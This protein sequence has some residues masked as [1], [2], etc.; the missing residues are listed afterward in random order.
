IDPRRDEIIRHPDLVEK[1]AEIG[2]K[3]VFIGLES[4][5]DEELRSLNKKCTVE[6]NNRA[7]EILHANNV[8]PLGAF[9]IQ[10]HYTRKH[11]DD[12]L[13]YL[14]R[15]RIYYH[16]FTVLTPFPGTEFYNQV[17]DEVLESDRR[18]YDLAHSMF[19]T[20]IPAAEFY[21]LLSR[22]YRRAQ[23]PVRA[24]RIRPNVSPF[25]RMRFLRLIPGILSLFVS[26]RRAYRRYLA[27]MDERAVARQ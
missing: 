15:M 25:Y 10:P 24:M 22:L 26:A 3:K 21:A 20:T 14:D 16:E 18:L 12:L 9:V 23:S 8:D 27:A 17:K 7:I 11:F 5:D 4:I 6:K 1:W 2:L 19:P 13:K